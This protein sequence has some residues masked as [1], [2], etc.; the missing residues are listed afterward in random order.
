VSTGSLYVPPQFN[1]TDIDKAQ[2]LVRAY[3]LAQLVSVGSEG[4]PFISPLPLETSTS[5]PWVLIG[6]LANANPQVALLKTNRKALVTVMGPQAYLSPT[7]YPDSQRVP[8]WNY[9]TLHAQVDVQPIDPATDK[10]ALLKALI[11]TH[12]P[13]YAEQWRGLPESYTE[14]MLRAITGFTLTVT[15][16]TLKVKVNQHRPEAKA[17]M[18]AQYAKGDGSAQALVEWI[19]GWQRP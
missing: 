16:W 7:V 11:K 13:P 12:E 6:H 1:C 5:D 8:T 19:E 14:A 4:A 17:A 15:A 9:V 3:P 18:L 10:D 2:A